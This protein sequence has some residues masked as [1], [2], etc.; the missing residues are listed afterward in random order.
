MKNKQRRINGAE[1]SGEDSRIYIPEV[2]NAINWVEKLR[3]LLVLLFLLLL[4]R[5]T[6]TSCHCHST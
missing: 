2:E 4:L 5:H 3:L 1:Q 6:S